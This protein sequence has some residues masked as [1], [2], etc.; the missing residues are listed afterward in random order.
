MKRDNSCFPII[1]RKTILLFHLWKITKTSFW[2]MYKNTYKDIAFLTQLP[3]F[4]SS[5]NH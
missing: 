3:L 1:L 4:I 5:N 2:K